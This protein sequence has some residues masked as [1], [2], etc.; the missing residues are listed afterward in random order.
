MDSI[1]ETV[2][3]K[4][5]EYQEMLNLLFS[6]NKKLLLQR[7]KDFK[8]YKNRE[9]KAEK[10]PIQP[11]KK[12]TKFKYDD[13]ENPEL[14]PLNT[15]EIKSQSKVK[16]VE[17]MN[18][19]FSDFEES[20]FTLK[21]NARFKSNTGSNILKI[22]PNKAEAKALDNDKILP[23]VLVKNSTNTLNNLNED[24][25]IDNFKEAEDEKVEYVSRPSNYNSFKLKNLSSKNTFQSIQE[26]PK[27]QNIE[28][29]LLKNVQAYKNL[30]K[31]E[32]LSGNSSRFSEDILKNVKKI[33]SQGNS[34]YLNDIDSELSSLSNIKKIGFTYQD[35][36]SPKEG[37]YFFYLIKRFYFEF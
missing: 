9:N 7:S 21:V 28:H 19:S 37:K 23:P 3:Q 29:T 14:K 10:K 34:E 26:P 18:H 33:Q 32:Q 16:M 15:T 20:E 11:K 6:V 17:I 35:L 27:N 31:A 1:I 22:N 36:G 2:K 12:H 24:Q 5:L 4:N 13:I 30:K 8:K 25:I